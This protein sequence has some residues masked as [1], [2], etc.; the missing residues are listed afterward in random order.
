MAKSPLPVRVVV[1][2]PLLISLPFL[3]QRGRLCRL[4]DNIMSG[5]SLTRRRWNGRFPLK[6]M[7]RPW[8]GYYLAKP[9]CKFATYLALQNLT[10]SIA[11]SEPSLGERWER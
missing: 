5:S 1:M 11:C 2:G 9:R 7:D 6:W 8:A 3:M 4:A 10:F